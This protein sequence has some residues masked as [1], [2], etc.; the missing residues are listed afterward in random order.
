[1]FENVYKIRCKYASSNRNPLA[2]DIIKLK[3]TSLPY[4]FP[5]ATR[6]AFAEKRHFGWTFI[7][8][9]LLNLTNMSD[10]G[11]G[12]SNSLTLINLIQGH[13]NIHFSKGVD[14]YN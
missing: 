3:I 9:L 5:S 6:N 1:M 2:L 11:S 7:Y 14:I 10:V 4:A 8:A 13:N 12:S